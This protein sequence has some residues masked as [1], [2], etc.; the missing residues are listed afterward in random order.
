[1]GYSTFPKPHKHPRSRCITTT[2]AIK[3]SRTAQHV[4]NTITMCYH[5]ATRY[6]YCQHDRDL[7]LT[8]IFPC[9]SPRSVYCSLVTRWS[10]RCGGD[11]CPLC[12]V[13]YW[14]RMNG[15][16]YGEQLL[17]F[18]THYG[19]PLWCKKDGDGDIVPPPPS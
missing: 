11:L 3:T 16:N 4:Q 17:R 6:I 7:A 1:M 14:N 19:L 2:T 5:S 9:Q 18:C 15:S 13:D 8:E 12:F 10:E